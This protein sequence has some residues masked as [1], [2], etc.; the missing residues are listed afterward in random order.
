MLF[1]SNNCTLSR[2]MVRRTVRLRLDAGMTDPGERSYT[3]PNIQR[4]TTER[5]AELAGAALWIAQE[6]IRAGEPFAANIPTL[7]SFE[8]WSRIIGGILAYVGFPGF[9]QDRK[10][11]KASANPIEQEWRE[12]LSLWIQQFSPEN[13]QEG[14]GTSREVR[15]AELV[16][17]AETHHL[18]Y[19]LRKGDKTAAVASF[20]LAM[21]KQIRRVY[22]L[23]REALQEAQKRLRL[24][25]PT[26]LPGP[27]PLPGDYR[28]Q[29][30]VSHKA[31][32]Y[33]LVHRS[34]WGE[35]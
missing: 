19:G 16:E 25:E 7:P 34:L 11:L 13:A 1:R 21:A 33:V 31:G 24:T 35:R 17:L 29:R 23:E 22:L 6:W 26:A 4:W 9:L 32:C 5:R 18:L 2:D 10:E 12:L 30:R 3:H 27:E 28:V 14:Y 8:D 20:G 15:S